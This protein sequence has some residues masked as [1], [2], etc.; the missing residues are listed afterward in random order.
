MTT[1]VCRV[2]LAVNVLLLCAC[3]KS[4][5]S[6]TPAVTQPPPA[7][8]TFTTTFEQNP[9]PFRSTGCSFSTPQGWYTAVRLQE[10]AGVSFTPAT[11][12][13]KLDGNTVSFLAESFGS[14]FGACAGAAFTSGVILAN[15]AVCGT[16]GVCTA[17][18]YTTYQFSITGTDANGHTITVDSPVLQLGA[19]PAGQS[20]LLT[21]SSL[22]SRP[23]QASSQ[24]DASGR[25]RP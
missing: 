11:L 22:P 7:T 24:I 3:G 12:T 15:G 25:I 21:P 20:I 13:Q 17:N 8:S 23:P 1:S 2:A 10:T 6:P 18:A 5:T 16:V 19:R 4:S 14:R 9:A